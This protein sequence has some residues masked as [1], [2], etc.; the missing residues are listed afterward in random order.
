MKMKIKSK[1]ERNSSIEMLRIIATIGII[2]HHYIEQGGGIQNTYGFNEFMCFLI[3]PL[4]KLG[5]NVFLIITSYYTFRSDIKIEKILKLW[6]EVFFYQVVAVIVCLVLNVGDTSKG[7]F[8]RSL[9]PILG[10]LNW[11]VTAYFGFMFAIPWLNRLIQDISEQEYKKLVIILGL[12]TCVLPTLLSFNAFVN[13]VIWFSFVYL[14]VGYL[15]EYEQER[16]TYNKCMLY[17]V[18]SYSLIVFGEL[19]SENV[20][21]RISP[22]HFS[23][24]NSM[25]EIIAA[26]SLFGLFHRYS[27]TNN[28]VNTVASHTF[29]VFLIHTVYPIR[30]HLLWQKLLKVSEFYSSKFMVLH[31]IGSGILI[32][33]SC[34]IIDAIYQ[35]FI[36]PIFIRLGL[37]KRAC[38]VLNRLLLLKQTN[39]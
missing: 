31:M 32:F 12:A 7:I 26:L 19:I 30:Y 33:V 8:V 29:G 13:D 35:R 11:Y 25:F 10:Q 37:F 2:L 16:I 28:L 24:M 38:Q 1:Y 3:T 20:L 18:V 14:L 9:F 34:M 15:K 27:I 4:G 22:S 5:V 39:T 17:F 6:I 21:T 36:A 23:Q